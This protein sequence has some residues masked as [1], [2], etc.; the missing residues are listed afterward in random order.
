MKNQMISPDT[1]VWAYRIVSLIILGVILSALTGCAALGNVIGGKVL[2]QELSE[3]LAGAT[4]A[5]FD[6]YTGSGNLAIDQLSG[7]EQLLA[8]GTLQY[9]ESL[10]QPARTLDSSNGQANLTLKWGENSAP[11]TAAIE[12]LLHLNPTVSSEIV[13]RS[14]GGNVSLNLAG[15]AVTRVSAETGGGNMDLVLPENT[16][17]LSVTAKTGAGNVVVSV[18]SG[19]AAKIHASTGLGKTIIDSRFTKIDENT[20]QSPDYES[21]ANKVEIT[22]GS[23]AGNVEIKTR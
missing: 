16:V 14:G 4:A 21:A 11:C 13:A 9:Q 3:P 7:S 6:I 22:A 8:S 12:W 19:T 23:G 17:N 20:Y 1:K 5:R 18:P 15:M 10:G 2:A